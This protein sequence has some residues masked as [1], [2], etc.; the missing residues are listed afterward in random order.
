MD[1]V[2]AVASEPVGVL[3]TVQS[4]SQPE[5]RIFAYVSS[6]NGISNSLTK[7]SEKKNHDQKKVLR[8]W[9]GRKDERTFVAEVANS[10]SGSEA[11]AYVLH[12]VT[13]YHDLAPKT[14]FLHAHDGSWHSEGICKLISR[15]ES[16]HERVGFLNLNK[17]YPRR[18]LSPHRA[19]G[20]FVDRRLWKQYERHW[21]L[22]TNS[23]PPRRITF[24]C[25]AQFVASRTSLYKRDLYVWARI[26]RSIAHDRLGG[27]WEYLWPTLVDEDLAV[28]KAN[29]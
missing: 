24:E 9:M 7:H 23:S 22:W 29:C 10:W 6:G 5:S 2:L 16:A 17:P 25:C 18:C 14:I 26:L 8:E 19:I 28:Q 15:S 13:H 1:V 4:C 11:S 27:T 20:P 21:D 3:E 12:I